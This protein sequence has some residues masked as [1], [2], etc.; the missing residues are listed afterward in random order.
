MPGGMIGKKLGMTQIFDES[1]NSVSVTVIEAGP[2]AVLDIRTPKK[3]GYASVALGFDQK[4][5]N[6]VNKPKRGFFERAGEVA[7]RVIREFRLPAD[8]LEKYKLG[9][10]ITAD[11]F[12]I[13][14]VINVTGR[15]KGK[16]FAGVVKRWGFSGGRKTHGSRFHRAPGSIGMCAW[17]ARTLKGKK[18]PGHK[19]SERVTVKNLVVVDV[20][21]ERNVILVKGAIPGAKN[22]IVEVKGKS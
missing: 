5:I 7:Y 21:K 20:K 16:G 2:C 9:Q 14:D 3:N 18:L 6:N 19:G 4:D 22:G 8:E 1:G 11:C 13:G 17:P 15:S 12:K 10:I